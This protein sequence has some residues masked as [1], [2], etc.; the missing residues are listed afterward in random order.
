[1]WFGV[2]F[3][4]LERLGNFR[5]KIKFLII[6]MSYIILVDFSLINVVVFMFIS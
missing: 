4:V 6:V 1:M 5:M 2:F 3:R